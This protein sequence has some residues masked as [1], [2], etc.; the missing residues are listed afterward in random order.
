M[1]R[2]REHAGELLGQELK[3]LHFS[4]KDAVVIGL[5]RGGVP[6]AYE[7]ARQLQLPLDIL[8]V[9]KIGYPGN[10]E[11]AL[12]AVT[13]DG[14]TFFNESL[15]NSSGL[16]QERIASLRERTLQL[17]KA[18]ANSLR[19]RHS[20]DVANKTVFLIDDGIATGATVEAALKLL[21]Q[22]G[23]TAIILAAPVAPLS[24]VDKFSKS[25][26]KVIFLDTP[27]I[28]WAVGQW[29]ERFEQ[30]DDEEVRELLKQAKNFKA[31]ESSFSEP[32]MDL[33]NLKLLARMVNVSHAKAW[34]VFAHG[35]GSSRLSRRNN[36]VADQLNK[37][38]FSTL[39]FD[40][41]TPEEDRIY[42]NRFNIDLLADRLDAAIKWLM[43]SAY[44]ET[45]T[46][47]GLFGASTGAAAALVTAARMSQEV[48]LY[49]V[50]SRGGRPDLAGEDNL[51]QVMTPTLLLVGS[52]DFGV[53][54]LNQDALAALPKGKMK[55][56]FG[57][58][59]LFEEPGTLDKVA[60]Y[61]I[62]WFEEHLMVS[63]TSREVFG[64]LNEGQ[65]DAR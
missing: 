45:N 30:V 13:E 61:S 7:V 2:D 63:P 31:S 14:D 36:W 50:V 52:N 3:K 41:L 60:S 8:C 53:I 65:L 10:P 19:T 4:T 48:P 55:L 43:G 23:A 37:A 11:L 22:K 51:E 59:H 57:A 24:A 34:I 40:L 16:S 9:K 39:L 54:E 62:E 1:F 32:E 27:K 17:A 5:P 20:V 12:G 38:G 29:Y 21:Q 33:A 28:F 49:A 46:P 6:V 35:S 26:D 47:I 56:V 64:A 25:A 15:K 42:E 58:T 18:Q 44:Y